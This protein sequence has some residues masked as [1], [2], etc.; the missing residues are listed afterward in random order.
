M[1][2]QSL[3]ICCSLFVN[4]I[5]FSQQTPKILTDLKANY[6]PDFSYAGY[7]FGE[8]QI[9]EATGKIINAV[10]FG[11]KTNDGLDDSKA[12]LK[13]IKAA[14]ETEGNVILQLPAGRIILSEVLYIERSNF[15]LRGA[16]SGENGTEIYCPRPM[17]YLK[18]PESLAELREYLTTFDKRQR[19][20]ENNVDLP[21][22]QY[23]WSGGFIWTQI[24]GE[25]VKSYLDKY[26][27]VP[28]V[29]AKVISGNM[30][31]HI[32]SVSDV[33]GLK[34]GDIVELQLFNKD[35]E[36]GE[37]IT[38][39]YK[40]AKVK[41]GSHHW[42]FPKLPI[43][44]QQVEITKISNS[45]ITIKT[46]LTIA[47]KPSYQAQLV[48]W[49]HL[50]EVG[51]EHLR[52]TFPNIPR[53][54]HH[55]E[56]GNN[57]IFLTRVFNSWVKDVTITNADS[58]IL[59]EEISNVTVQD[60]VTDGNHMAH[61]TV[62]LG[63]VHN[64]LVKNLKIYNKTVHPLSFN[65]FATKNVYLNC[66]IF[67]DPLL[68]QH[69]GANHQNLFDHITVHINPDKNNSYLLFGGGGADYWKPSHGPFSTFWNLNVQVEKPS[70]K[71][72]LLYGMKDGPFA[73]I[74]GVNG[75][76]KFEVK[77]EPD[78]YIEFLNMPLDQIPSLYDYQ[79]KKRLK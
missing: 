4:S 30:G 32:I 41:P 52:F 46:P 66:E 49:K 67:A 77:Y 16:G 69:S 60:I 38:D 36:N 78:A 65:T 18:N 50:N 7:H 58:G 51:I 62:T 71:P 15:V 35:G 47:I 39:L 17:M 64:V 1:N 75:N 45:K 25:R 53:V 43:V 42:K 73:R 48:E 59:G 54:A 26:E 2:S 19:E 61:Y 55:V 3:I 14:T 76:A 44:R 13:A 79:L 24:P 74:I 63:G 29:L 56:P 10:D 8:S 57:A 11:V 33:K 28:N 40:G 34:V 21:F 5:A 23:A 9:P 22:S 68:D 12:L 72:V 6:L 31:E 70:D 27:P 37:I 20:P